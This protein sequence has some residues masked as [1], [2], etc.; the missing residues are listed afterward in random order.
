M[1]HPRRNLTVL[2]AA[3]LSLGT[4][5]A[6][7][8][9]STA[10]AA[11]TAA[12]PTVVSRVV[13]SVQGG[14]AITTITYAN[15]DVSKVYDSAGAVTLTPSSSVGTAGLAGALPT[16]SRISTGA[17]SVSQAVTQLGGSSSTAAA[18]TTGQPASD[19]SATSA[20][21]S[22]AAH[23]DSAWTGKLLY[24][25]VTGTSYFQSNK[26]VVWYLYDQYVVYKDGWTWGL[27]DENS[28]IGTGNGEEVTGLK[29]NEHYSGTNRILDVN[30]ATQFDGGCISR[31]YS[32]NPY[33]IGVAATIEDCP[34]HWGAYY[35]SSWTY[36]TKWDGAGSGPRYGTRETGGVDY[37]YNPPSAD[38]NRTWSW[39]VWWVS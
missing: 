1:G 31:L 26:I 8:T 7:A 20:S 33:G 39:Q 32:V 22:P 12:S 16:T 34:V 4:T 23:P 28:M 29:Q 13:R 35:V 3:A 24:N 2:A 21:S 15:G 14:G 18:L 5:A 6:L 36:E 17:L 25:R 9:P 37:D 10:N 19:V 30:P 38:P 11:N 27:A